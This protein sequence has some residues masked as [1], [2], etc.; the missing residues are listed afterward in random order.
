[1]KSRFLN[2]SP[3]AYI[4]QK[5]SV[6]TLPPIVRTGYQNELGKYSSPF[7]DTK[8][9][10]VFKNSQVLLAPYMISGEKAGSSGF[11]TGTLLVTASLGD[12]NAFLEKSINS[13]PINPFKEGS[14][15]T[16]YLKKSD[17]LGFP[18][19]NYPG[20]SSSDRDK[21]AL[22]FDISTQADFDVLKLNEGDAKNTSGP[23]SGQQGSGFLYY[24]YLKKSWQDIGT[25]DPSTG[26][27]IKYDPV[28]KLDHQKLTA[29]GTSLAQVSAG[30]KEFLCQFASS[31]YSIISEGPQY[32]PKSV[33]AL[34]ARGY[35][36]I[37]EPT[38]FFEA[39]YAPRY[40]ATTGSGIRLSDY[41][42]DPF[43]VDRITVTLPVRAVRTQTPPNP[44]E[45]PTL[46]D[47]GFG[48]D[49][50][51][52]V[53]FIYVQNRSNANP[54]SRQDV[55]SSLRYLIA[56]ESFCFFNEIVLDSVSLGTRP[57]HAYAK[58]LS[59]SMGTKLASSSLSPVSQSIDA[60][61]KMNFRPL[62]FQSSFGTTSKLA[63][64]D[65]IV[66][67]PAALTSS[68]F[69][70]NFWRGGQIGS[71]S[72]GLI[73][74][75]SASPAL[76]RNLNAMSGAIPPRISNLQCQPSTRALVSSFWEG[77]E[78]LIGSGSGLSD[79]IAPI[80]TVSTLA[81][82]RQTPVVLFPEDE[83]VFGIESGANSNIQSPGR[84]KSGT[85][86]SVLDVT[87]SRLII[88]SGDANI[89]LYGSTISN[90]VQSLP[91]LNQHLGSDAIHEAIQESGPYD[92]FDT[93]DKKILS[94][95]YVDNFI[96]GSISIGSLTRKIHGR[97]TS[98]E[99]GITGSLQRNVRL[100]FENQ[101]YHDTFLPA[102]AVITTN[103]RNTST[104]L[105][106]LTRL[107]AIIMQAESGNGYVV[108]NNRSSNI[109]LER[110]FT[111]EK[112]QGEARVRNVVVQLLTS[113]GA[114][115]A[116]DGTA[117]GDAA[118]FLLYYNGSNS[119]VLVPTTINKKYSGAASIR[120]GMMSTRLMGPSCVFRRDRFGQFRDMLEQGR[121]GKIVTTQGGKDIVGVPVTA[122]KFVKQQT[123]TP[124]DPSLTQCSNL[125]TSC[126]SSI[127]FIDDGVFHNRGALPTTT[128]VSSGPNNLIF[129][130]TVTGSF[131]L[132]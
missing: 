46:F 109:M 121:D 5:D 77:D 122:A 16:A 7:D 99:T 4:R 48:R 25:R 24:D 31:P 87:G 93:Y 19:E 81:P 60:V 95:S 91:S 132:Q 26:Q 18:E 115:A 111:Y 123:S 131:G 85:D 72:T 15:I 45:S 106:V 27:T 128:T 34:E 29:P 55:S 53:F 125:S 119:T 118:R 28:L 54:D 113:A 67:T 14:N 59:F 117:T 116:P 13:S 75:R 23:F 30:N 89:T 80:E 84:Q 49:I 126:T 58:A 20:F 107:P 68:V 65:D 124:V 40:H 38:S 11:L 108:E 47:Y 69:I 10:I 100:Q 22:I 2:V 37:G 52:H 97:G 73:D 96:G 103:L 56:K 12:S 102:P 104:G 78:F 44:L 33:E 114:G 1:M 9:T 82:A 86:R 76:I 36:R 35:H 43:V 41:I 70:Q 57:I 129:G 88:K 83:L 105:T 90:K 127:P 112:E 64:S 79:T 120:Y 130:I 50:D 110:P 17:G 101:T 92:Q 63:G 66:S 42:N 3:R 71:G 8:S 51:N 21:T 74:L 6:N 32:V 62:T 61:I 98:F 94:A 39:P